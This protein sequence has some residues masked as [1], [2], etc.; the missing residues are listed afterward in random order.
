MTDPL[1]VLI[2]L[3][4]TIPEVHK[5]LKDRETYKR[6][7]VGGFV[8][9]ADGSGNTVTRDVVKVVGYEKGRYLLEDGRQVKKKQISC[10]LG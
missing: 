5:W 8:C 6:W 9:I 7:C 3:L 4:I 2:L 1:W 10:T